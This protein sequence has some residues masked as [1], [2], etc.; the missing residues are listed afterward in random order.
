MGKVAGSFVIILNIV[1]VLSVDEI[2][3]LAQV[4]GPDANGTAA[5]AR[6]PTS[7]GA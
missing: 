2:A 1:R 4:A 5:P 6:S 7:P 3:L